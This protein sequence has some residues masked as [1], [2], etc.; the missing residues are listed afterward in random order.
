MIPQFEKEGYLPPGFH[1][2]T[3]DEFEKRFAYTVWR[4]KLFDNLIKLI[5]DL[6]AT[7]CKEIYIDGSFTTTK[8]IPGDMDIC[9]E[10][11]GLDYNKVK[12]IMPILFDFAN[13][14]QNQQLMYNADIFPAHSPATHTGIL[15]INFFQTDKLTGNQKGIIKIII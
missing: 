10:D 1:L 13:K 12:A 2:T 4:K 7:G 3:I 11:T 8:I 6:K 9:W 15:Y 14:R 5:K